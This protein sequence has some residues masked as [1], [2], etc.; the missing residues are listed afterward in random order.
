M[1]RTPFSPIITTNHPAYS[2]YQGVASPKNFENKAISSQR[3]HAQEQRRVAPATTMSSPREAKNTLY[4]QVP[5]FTERSSS[6]KPSTDNFIPGTKPRE[7]SGATRVFFMQR[8]YSQ[9]SLD[10][11][12][13]SARLKLERTQAPVQIRN[14]DET[15]DDATATENVVMTTSTLG[16]ATF[17]PGSIQPNKYG[18]AELRDIKRALL[19]FRGGH[20]GG[21]KSTHS[22]LLKTARLTKA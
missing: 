21:T 9:K 18:G 19:N 11:R 5:H 8:D 3:N 16:G 20:T 15:P 22:L 13:D 6:R 4:S 1:K 14:R 2:K 10:N 17:G 12:A 7:V